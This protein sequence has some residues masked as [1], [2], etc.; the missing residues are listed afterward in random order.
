MD[1]LTLMCSDCIQQGYQEG[2][3]EGERRFKPKWLS[4]EYLPEGESKNWFFISRNGKNIGSN[5]TLNQ[6]KDYAKSGIA[7]HFLELVLPEPP[8][9][10]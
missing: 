5:Y 4:V 9:Y 1:E 3:K 7:T 2:I 8:N 10:R 6:V